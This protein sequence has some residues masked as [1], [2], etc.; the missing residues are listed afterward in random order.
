MEND[1]WKWKLFEVKWTRGRWKTII[2]RIDHDTPLEWKTKI[3]YFLIKNVLL[4][5][6]NFA[7]SVYIKEKE[8]KKISFVIL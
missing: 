8:R 6:I 3:D 1:E 7:L 5:I 4:I 2:E